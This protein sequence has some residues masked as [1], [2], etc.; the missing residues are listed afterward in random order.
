MHR[1]FT[2]FV[3]LLTLVLAMGVSVTPAVAA[4]GGFNSAKYCSNTGVIIVSFTL[5]G[6]TD[7]GNGQDTVTLDIW[8]SGSLLV[9]ENFQVAVGSSKTF[10][11]QYTVGALQDDPPGAGVYLVDAGTLD[12]IDP[13][14]E[15]PNCPTSGGDD[16]GGGAAVETVGEAEYCWT[17]FDFVSA[18]PAPVSGELRFLTGGTY[19]FVRPEGSNYATIP[20]TAGQYTSATIE[21][22]PCGVHV[23]AWLF[24]LS[25]NVVGLVPSQNENGDGVFELYG[26]DFGTGPPAGTVVVASIAPPGPAYYGRYSD[27]IGVDNSASGLASG[28][29]GYQ[30]PGQGGYQPPSALPVP[31]APPSASSVY[32]TQGTQ[33]T[34]TSTT[35]ST[36]SLPPGVA[37]PPPSP[38]TQNVPPPPP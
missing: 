4:T 7:D 31:P 27:I 38:Y 17:S 1:K 37:E 33:S 14:P 25:G 2:S 28:Q 30:Q 22:V 21:R 8:D 5:T 10:S 34:T 15:D 9:T 32:G 23:R 16:G 13:I 24:D 19:E 35:T 6:T 20:V 12:G 3:V 18:D 11:R 26:E 29:G 36:Q